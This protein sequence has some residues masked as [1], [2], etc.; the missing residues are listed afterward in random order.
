VCLVMTLDRLKQTE[1]DI[2]VFP[3]EG[4]A[5]TAFSLPRRVVVSCLSSL[6]IGTFDS[7]GR[8]KRSYGRLCCSYHLLVVPTICL[9][10]VRIFRYF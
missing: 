8:V 9:S 6:L 2:R 10:L 1:G 7:G 4:L 3:A 5:K